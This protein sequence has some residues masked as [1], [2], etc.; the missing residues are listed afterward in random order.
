[1]LQHR[2]WWLALAVM[3]SMEVLCVAGLLWVTRPGIDGHATCI[4]APLV[5]P[6]LLGFL[7]F[8]AVSFAYAAWC[9]ARLIKDEWAAR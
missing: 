7:A 4:P 9:I 1:V 5:I 6:P 3:A 8:A 2:H